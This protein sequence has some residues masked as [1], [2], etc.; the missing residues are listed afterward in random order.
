VELGLPLNRST[1]DRS[2]A[3]YVF[4][5]QIVQ[6]DS[7]GFL[8]GLGVDVLGTGAGVVYCNDAKFLHHTLICLSWD[9]SQHPESN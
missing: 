4:C 2:N 8:H 7:D 3:I 5:G 6:G 1:S 9:Q